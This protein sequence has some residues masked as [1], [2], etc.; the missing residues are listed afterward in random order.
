MNLYSSLWVRWEFSI[1]FIPWAWVECGRKV[2][3]ARTTIYI[4]LRRVSKVNYVLGLTINYF[5][6]VFICFVSS[7]SSSSFRSK[8]WDL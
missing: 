7:S 8:R 3:S 5:W 4:T 6:C 2:L 1:V